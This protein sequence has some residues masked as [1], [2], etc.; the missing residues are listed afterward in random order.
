MEPFLNILIPDGGNAV[1]KQSGVAVLGPA[2]RA[3]SN[4]RGRKDSPCLNLAL[5]KY[6]SVQIPQGGISHARSDSQIE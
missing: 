6:H 3:V 1:Y 5:L 2:A 4:S